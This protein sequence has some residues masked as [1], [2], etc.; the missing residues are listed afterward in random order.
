MEAGKHVYCEKPLTHNIWEARRV[1]QLTKETGLSTQMGNQRHSTP[2]V[3]KVVE[4]LRAG[5]IGEVRELHAWVPATRW[6]TELRTIPIT[7]SPMPYDFNWDLWLGPRSYR[8][9]HHWYSPVTWRDFWD[10]GCGA[11]GDFGCHDLDAAVW[12]LELPLP[13]SVQVKA[14]GFSD[15]QITPYGEI[16]YYE[17]PHKDGGSIKLNWYSGGL[18][19]RRP[20]LLPNQ[21]ELP[22]RGNM[23]VGD[24]GVMITGGPNIL[25]IYPDQLSSISVPETL[26]PSRGHHRDW[27]DAIK[28]GPQ[29]SSHFEYGAHLTEITLL[30]VLSLRL[31]GKIIHW[32]AQTMQAHGMPEAESYVQ[33]SVRSGW[34][35]G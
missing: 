22:A 23:F 29:A 20:E 24:K 32:D 12:G 19:P 3:R 9:F 17:F 6:I 18:Q 27:I 34:E 25:E 7:G 2:G 35:M 31:G 28:G 11:M 30:G 13:S 8:P 1:A 33:E 15:F 5:V 16:G 10:F 4:Y 21:V 14:A 26:P